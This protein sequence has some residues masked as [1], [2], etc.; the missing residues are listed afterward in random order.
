MRAFK[1]KK[2]MAKLSIIR[3]SELLNRRRLMHLFLNDI[4][5]GS[6]QNGETVCFDIPEGNYTLYA[7]IDWCGSKSRNVFMKEHV[8]TSYVLSGNRYNLPTILALLIV[9]VFVGYGSDLFP[10]AIYLASLMIPLLFQLIYMLTL[11]R[12]RYLEIKLL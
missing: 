8:E 6:I 9:S 3:K 7:K 1:M 5:I 10:N 2:I 12:N 11:G 4:H